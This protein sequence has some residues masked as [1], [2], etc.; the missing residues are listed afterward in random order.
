VNTDFAIDWQHGAGC[1]AHYAWLSRRGDRLV[2]WP[3]APFESSH[4]DCFALGDD[5]WIW[6]PGVGGMRFS[7]CH[8]D[9]EVLSERG[10]DRDWF[11]YL[12]RRCWLPP[13]FQIRGRQVLHASAV[14]DE[15]TG[16][17]IVFSGPSGAG[18]STIAYGM[19]RRRGRQQLCDDAV[20]FSASRDAITLHPIDSDPRLR[21]ASAEFFGVRDGAPSPIAWPVHD[22]RLQRIYFL[23]PQDERAVGAHAVSITL[24]R[25]ADA[26]QQLL[27]QAHALTLRLPALNHRLMLDYLAVAAAVP[28]CLLTYRR[29]FAH[30]DD[31][32]DAIEWAESAIA[33]PESAHAL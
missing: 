14:M 12:V 17:A 16:E 8:A 23:E 7:A 28:A 20:A 19:A 32:F 30:I 33:V 4:T 29:S 6:Q 26:Y 2:R 24:L 5:Y 13:L 1:A 31:V 3:A 9:I 18:K 10:V 22:V 21:P 15:T 25:A 27:K 11:A